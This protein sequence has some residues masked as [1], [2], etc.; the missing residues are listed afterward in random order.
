MRPLGPAWRSAA[1]SSYELTG[2]EAVAYA[3]IVKSHNKG[4]LEKKRG[5]FGTPLL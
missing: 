3:V 1:V 4:V 2:L 5:I